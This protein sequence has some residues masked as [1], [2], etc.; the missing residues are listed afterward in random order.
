VLRFFRSI[1]RGYFRRHFHAVRISGTERFAAMCQATEPLILYANHGSWWDPM[2]AFLLAERWMPQF[3]HFA[4]MDAQALERYQILK[5]VGIFPVEI[6]TARGAVQFL[7]TSEAIARSGGVLWITPQGKFVDGRVR[8]LAFKPGL[9]ALAVRVADNV[10]PCRVQPLAIEYT[11]WD[12]RLP[13]CLLH[14]GEPVLVN[15]G[16]TPSDVETRLIRALEDGMDTLKEL[17]VR[18]DA[19][20]FETMARGT[21]GAGGFYALGQRIKSLFSGTPYRGEHTLLTPSR[22]G[23]KKC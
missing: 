11:F 23:S 8:P 14:L 13:E 20:L 22:E 15:A 6:A 5:H 16:D 1:V 2:V 3:Q 7:R 10:G 9:A 19:A 17:A 21:V 4:P 18:R 12:E